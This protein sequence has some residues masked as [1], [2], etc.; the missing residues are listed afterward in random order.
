MSPT[1][2]LTQQDS[3]TNYAGQRKKARSTTT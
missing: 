3:L 1:Q 2:N